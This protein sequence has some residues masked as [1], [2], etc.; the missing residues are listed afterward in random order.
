MERSSEFFIVRSGSQRK[1]T[2]VHVPIITAASTPSERDSD[3]RAS[4]TSDAL[5]SSQPSGSAAASM[6]NNRT[7]QEYL[8]TTMN[9]CGSTPQL[10][11]QSSVGS[12]AFSSSKKRLTTSKLNLT[13]ISR[14]GGSDHLKQPPPHATDM[15]QQ[16]HVEKLKAEY[17]RVV[18][19]CRTKQSDVERDIGELNKLL[20]KERKANEQLQGENQAL[21]DQINQLTLQLHDERKLTLQ[22]KKAFAKLSQRYVVVN[23]TL[24]TLTSTQ[25]GTKAEHGAN[26]VLHTMSKQNQEYERRIRVLET[27]HMDDT[28]S[29]AHAEKKLKMIKMELES[30]EH[31]QMAQATNAEVLEEKAHAKSD[32]T[33][34]TTVAS[35][36]YNDPHIIIKAL[37]EQYIDPSILRI[38]H[39]VDS[40]FDIS[41][42]INL[43]TTFKRWL[44][45][46]QSINVSLDE[47][48][49]TQELLKKVCSVLQCEHAA[50]Y[51]QF[52]SPKKLVCCFTNAGESQLE[53]PMDKGIVGH[54]FKSAS[55]CGVASAYEDPRFCSTEDNM[56]ETI[57]RDIM[58]VP[59]FDDKNEICGVLRASNSMHG[60]TFSANELIILG[61]FAIQA[62][63]LLQQYQL[64]SLLH[65]SQTK[66]L[67][68]HDMP[69]KLASE[70]IPTPE[71]A[72][73]IRFVL[74]TERHFHQILGVTKFKMFL[75]DGDVA[76]G[77]GAIW[78]VGKTLD[79][80]CDTTYFRQY[81]KLSSSL[82][83]LAIYHPKGLTIPD[84]MTHAK[85]N[86]AIDLSNPTNGMYL[87]PIMSLWGKPLGILQVGRSLT[88]SKGP[89]AEMIEKQTADDA[90]RLHL[91]TLF[92]HSIAS[93]LHQLTA[94]EECIKTP[95]E[96][97]D[98]RVGI[99]KGLVEAA[100]VEMKRQ[101]EEREKR[102]AMLVGKQDLV[103]H[104]NDPHAAR[105]VLEEP[106]DSDRSILADD[107][108][109]SAQTVEVSARTTTPPAEATS[110]P[111]SSRKVQFAAETTETTPAS[112]TT[113]TT[114]E[115]APSSRPI[116]PATEQTKEIETVRPITPIVAPQSE[117]E[118]L[119]PT[120]PATIPTQSKLNAGQQDQLNTLEA[121]TLS[122][123]RVQTA[124]LPTQS[125]SFTPATATQAH[126][127][128]TEMSIQQRPSTSPAEIISLDDQSIPSRPYSSDTTMNRPTTPV[129][130][131]HDISPPETATEAV[132]R[133]PTVLSSF[134]DTRPLTTTEGGIV[135][136]TWNNGAPTSA[137]VDASADT[138]W[139]WDNTAVIASETNNEAGWAPD[140]MYAETTFEAD[141][142][143]AVPDT[144]DDHA[145]EPS[146]ETAVYA[147]GGEAEYTPQYVDDPTLPPGW[148][149]IAHG[150]HVYYENNETGEHTWT[151]PSDSPTTT[152]E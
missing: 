132:S 4:T 72:S 105:K 141:S 28:K 74:A 88:S 50:I 61:V 20:H 98:A 103:H 8:P 81:Y 30:I 12:L 19:A 147:T 120:T 51:R 69:R 144:H 10:P 138:T 111:V 42:A 70:S 86:G 3:D 78:C 33:P 127:D 145:A 96:A 43:S 83:G 38:L 139:A 125:R 124:P 149:A 97:R 62:G 65:V 113:K 1:T 14:N 39:E 137:G 26:T 118:I 17:E 5:S 25:G 106:P 76:D 114:M 115:S 142:A 151:R 18:A 59:L 24:H 60:K 57:T 136:E 146:A 35:I 128:K 11:L 64:E 92:A 122:S 79:A 101:N 131:V 36:N 2:K 143:Y 84:P 55:P 80:S 15:F 109:Q 73:L 71:K 112:A 6:S 47:C 16:M 48:H 41:N 58:C 110:R 45:S 66:L 95:D 53:V 68:L 135:P 119:R 126:P 87:V 102:L 140:A 44:H 56:T 94:Y 117:R 91:I 100:E 85:Y 75:V 23:D 99:V 40:Q 129:S 54:V 104:V 22:Q 9:R 90:L 49:I 63:L 46:C 32:A 130:D 31:M 133:E 37:L 116:T 21:R 82:C 108:S 152:S 7:P 121:R 148:V 123:P 93:L 52:T 34:A 67:R 134:D 29:L 27:Q 150:E 77:G 89:T 107:E 13:P